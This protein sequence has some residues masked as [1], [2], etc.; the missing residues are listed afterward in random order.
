[1]I[2]IFMMFMVARMIAIMTDDAPY[3]ILTVLN[4]RGYYNGD[5]EYKG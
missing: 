2:P 3:T 5:Y 1:M 4:R